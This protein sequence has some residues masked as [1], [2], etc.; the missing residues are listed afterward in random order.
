[1]SLLFHPTNDYELSVYY[2]PYLLWCC[3]QFCTSSQKSVACVVSWKNV[4]PFEQTCQLEFSAVSMSFGLIFLF[5]Y[6]PSVTPK[7]QK[8]LHPFIA[9]CQFIFMSVHPPVEPFW[10]HTMTVVSS[11]VTSFAQWQ[12]KL[13]TWTPAAPTMTQYAQRYREREQQQQSRVL[14]QKGC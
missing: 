5:Y 13:Y 7:L 11:F 14:Q 4:S 3:C 1:M 9:S 8:C 10:G 12:H 6:F 2:A